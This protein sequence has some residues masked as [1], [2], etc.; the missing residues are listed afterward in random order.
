MFVTHRTLFPWEVSKTPDVRAFLSHPLTGTR[1]Y[2]WIGSLLR[3]HALRRRHI[4]A[5]EKVLPAP[6]VV[7]AR[8]EEIQG[9]IVEKG[10]TED[11]T[12]C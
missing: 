11:E 8:M 12:I 1:P 10:F 2:C 5:M 3:R 4:T 7:Q 9:T 6:A